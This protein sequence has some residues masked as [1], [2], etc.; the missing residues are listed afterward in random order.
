MKARRATAPAGATRSSHV[1]R[2]PP[3]V[4]VRLILIAV[5]AGGLAVIAIRYAE[6]IIDGD[7]FWHL[8]YAEQ[9][10]ERGTLIP[11]HTLY[12]WTPASNAM[13][14][15]A[16]L[17][18]LVL[19]GIYQLGGLPILF[20]F[21]YA[22]IGVAAL[23]LFLHARALGITDRL[24]TY[25]I[26]L[27][28]LLASVAGTFIKPE[29]FSFLFFHLLVF[30]YCR[31]RAAD[32]A[33]DRERARNWFLAVPVIVLVWANSHGGFILAA[34]FFVATFI[35]ELLTR[36]Y[37]SAR[38]LSLKSLK[39]LF[40]AWALS[41]LAVFVT[42][43]G[44]RYPWQL[45]TDYA[46]RSTPRPDEG[47]NA[48]HQS[49]LSAHG[50][51]ELF[52]YGIALVAV[53]AILIAFA[54][55]RVVR[56]DWGLLIASACYAPLYLVYGRT[57][58]YFVVLF[59]YVA[60][61]VFARVVEQETS[62]AD[63]R[64]WVLVT[65]A[66]VLAIV[67]AANALHAARGPADRGGWIGFGIG[68]INPVAEAEF[69]A[70]S[71][72]G[73]R[74]YNLFDSGGYLLWRLH[75]TYQV[76][77]DQRS[78]PYLAWFDEQYRFANG[79]YFA[80]FLKKYPADTAVIDLV[81]AATWRN[82]LQS[83]DWKLAFYGSAAAVFVRRSTPDDRLASGIARNRFEHMR[84]GWSALN[85]FDFALVIGDYRVAWMVLTQLQG[86]LRSQI[87]GARLAQSLAVRDGHRA[88]ASGN[89]DRALE[90]FERAAKRPI[91]GWREPVVFKLLQG[92]AAAERAGNA[93]DIARIEAALRELTLP[94]QTLQ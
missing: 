14:Y 94:K 32:R 91:Q 72:L 23:L 71:K 82:F 79:E 12:S 70:A 67:V 65:C 8:K 34:P 4:T 58:F 73:P 68:D 36:R 47:W 6:P 7:L 16:W 13:I 64:R 89:F 22:C 55:R 29:I 25:A 15:C 30:A 3:T 80:E 59:G 85:A 38:A 74:L 28:S 81:R 92:F 77:V 90:L 40:S 62:G 93:A 42:P 10:L 45:V 1:W 86:A 5:V 83:P 41:A 33:G 51:T 63:R 56:V 20:A 17:A 57:T 48:A 35:G 69:L 11:D 87:D 66:I 52:F 26:V 46:L 27:F 49:I 2:K 60:L 43:Y 39:A 19:Y 37:A 21:R 75:P 61:D 18:E 24:P 78:F 44:W 88:L 50:S 31:A 84:N 54:G 53:A 76:M 9:I